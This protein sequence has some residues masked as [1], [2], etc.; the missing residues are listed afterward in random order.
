[1]FLES[2]NKRNRRLRPG[3]YSESQKT[4]MA[5]FSA[6]LIFCRYKA[7]ST[8]SLAWELTDRVTGLQGRPNVWLSCLSYAEPCALIGKQG[9]LESWVGMFEGVR[10]RILNT[11][12][13]LNP[14]GWKNHPFL[15]A[16]GDQPS[17]A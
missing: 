10:M 7:D 13:V 16:R 4:P 11:Q 8:E 12:T 15:L 17:L 6:T 3:V 9:D 2:L 14:P 1:M 5:T